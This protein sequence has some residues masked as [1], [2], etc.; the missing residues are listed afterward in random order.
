MRNFARIRTNYSCI[1]ALFPWN[2]P[3]HCSSCSQ[4]GVKN[5]RKT[6]EYA[7]EEEHDEDKQENDEAE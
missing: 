5:K 1:N 3:S 7:E 6:Q 4:N 2:K